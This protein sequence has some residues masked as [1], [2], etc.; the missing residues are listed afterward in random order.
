MKNTRT[1]R[2]P[3]TLAR[4]GLAALAAIALCLGLASLTPFAAQAADKGKPGKAATPSAAPASPAACTLTHPD[5]PKNEWAMCTIADVEL[6]STPAIGKT[7]KAVLTVKSQ[8]AVQDAQVTLSVNE[9]F[10][11]VSADG[12]GNAR[13]RA[14]GIGPVRPS[15]ARPTWP[16]A[17][18][19]PTVH[20]AR[21]VQGVRRRPGPCED[22]RCAHCRE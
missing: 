12:F 11:V 21:R 2:T 16:P 7:T 19:R 20:P 4:R 10:E 22:R 15:A 1:R 9:N 18:P 3:R 13:A 17:A 5:Q 14:S 8:E 6:Q